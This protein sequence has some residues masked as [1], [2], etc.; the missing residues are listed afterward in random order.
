MYASNSQ[1]R[2]CEAKAHNHRAI[3]AAKALPAQPTYLP[4][5]M[6]ADNDLLSAIKGRKSP[7]TWTSTSQG[8]VWRP[9]VCLLEWSARPFIQ[10]FNLCFC[11]WVQV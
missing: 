6:R 9:C 3:T 7:P 5:L 8:S 4:T 11:H 2:N 1:D 10:I